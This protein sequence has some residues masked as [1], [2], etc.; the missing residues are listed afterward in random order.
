[1]AFF[2]LR[3]TLFCYVYGDFVQNVR[4]LRIRTKKNRTG[5]VR[6]PYTETSYRTY[7]ASV[8]GVRTDEKS[9]YKVSVFVNVISVDSSCGF[10]IE[11]T[12][13]GTVLR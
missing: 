11:R 3:G 4:S 5:S 13:G 7:G 8:Y 9:L 1:M 6:T 12:S 10:V 2:G